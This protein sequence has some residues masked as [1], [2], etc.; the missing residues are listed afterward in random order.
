MTETTDWYSDETATL[1]DRISGGREA[2]GIDQEE[3]ARRIGVR[4][5][6]LRKWEEDRAE[7]RANRVQML[8]GILGVSLSWLLT[9]KGEG[10]DAPHEAELPADVVKLLDEMRTLHSQIARASTRLG[11]VEKALRRRL[12]E[13]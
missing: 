4:L 8:A 9:G 13:G 1:G 5:D 10:P 12:R 3:L 2:L 6:T 7:P 11:Q